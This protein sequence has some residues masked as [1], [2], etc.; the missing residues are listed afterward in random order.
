MPRVC[1]A[2]FAF[3]ARDPGVEYSIEANYYEIYN[4]V[5]RDLLQP[6][7][8]G[9]PKLKVREAK[10]G[11]I[12]DGLSHFAVTCFEDIQ[13]IMWAPYSSHSAGSSTL[14]CWM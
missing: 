9:G 4:E 5:L 8:S 7:G 1:Q 10:Q 11:T 2:I 12:I 3:S 6:Q 14:H 13:C